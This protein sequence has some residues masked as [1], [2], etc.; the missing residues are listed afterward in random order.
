MNDTNQNTGNIENS[1]GTYHSKNQFHFFVFIIHLCLSTM[2]FMIVFFTFSMMN[3]GVSSVRMKTGYLPDLYFWKNKLSSSPCS[4]IQIPYFGIS[5][6]LCP[7]FPCFRGTIYPMLLS[8]K[9]L[10]NL[11]NLVSFFIVLYL[12]NFYH[13]F[14]TTTQKKLRRCLAELHIHSF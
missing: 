8:S 3:F 13:L 1:D 6:S 4:F 2:D 10:F 12:F 11:N 5:M 9:N 14:I 7:F